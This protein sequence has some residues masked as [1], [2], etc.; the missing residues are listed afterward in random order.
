MPSPPCR[1]WRRARTGRCWKVTS[2]PTWSLP[3]RPTSTAGSAAG[4]TTSN[5]PDTLRGLTRVATIV[6]SLRR[7]SRLQPVVVD[8]G[9][10]IQGNPLAFVAARVDSTMPNPVIAAMNVIDYD[11]A[12]VGNHEF[13][14]GRAVPRQGGAPG[15]V[16][17]ARRERLH[18]RRDTEAFRSWTLST[19]LGIRVGDRRRDDA[20]LDGLGPRQ[21]GGGEARHPRHRAG[22]ARGRPRRARRRR[23]R[24]GRRAALRAR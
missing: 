16:P 3:R 11:A 2:Q 9:D 13:N 8:A 24:R 19:R 7:V 12:V 5:A 10:I 18:G 15:R 22:G 20:R 1:A 23:G 14:Y 17:A 4:T 6:D 21:P